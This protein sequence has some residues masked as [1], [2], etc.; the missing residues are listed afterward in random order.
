MQVYCKGNSWDSSGLFQKV[1]KLSLV[2]VLS[3]HY[4]AEQVIE[5]WIE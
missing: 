4:Q 2:F 3:K 5:G 1:G